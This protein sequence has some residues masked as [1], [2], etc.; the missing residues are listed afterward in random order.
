MYGRTLS[1][2]RSVSN[3]KLHKKG[4]QMKTKAKTKTR[5][6]VAKII[7]KNLNRLNRLNEEVL[8][9][10]Y[11]KVYDVGNPNWEEY[12]EFEGRFYDLLRD[13]NQMDVCEQDYDG[14]DNPFYED[15]FKMDCRDFRNFCADLENWFKTRFSDEIV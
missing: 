5:K 4:T 7:R 2:E 11:T 14:Q 1:A 8:K 9:K 15:E 13:W 3:E 10:A 12:E 6:Q